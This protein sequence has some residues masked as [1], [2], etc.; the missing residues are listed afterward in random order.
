MRLYI[1]GQIVKQN[2]KSSIGLI[3]ESSRLYDIDMPTINKEIERN[4][5][6]SINILKIYEGRIALAYWTELS[7]IFN[8]LAKEFQFESRKT[9]FIRGI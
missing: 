2:V 7:K 8:S 3:E 1:A 9:Y 4:N 5:Y 6:G